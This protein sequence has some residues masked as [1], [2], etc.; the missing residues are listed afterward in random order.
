M[1]C[2][3]SVGPLAAGFRILDLW[4]WFSRNDLALGE[5]FISTRVSSASML[6]CGTMIGGGGDIG[7]ASKLEPRFLDDW[8]SER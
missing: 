7:A 6:S 8:T 3:D 4:L 1:R 5:S 2:V